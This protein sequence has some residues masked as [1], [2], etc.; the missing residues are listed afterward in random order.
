MTA[1]GNIIYYTSLNVVS[2]SKLVGE[3]RSQQERREFQWEKRPGDT[4]QILCEIFGLSLSAVAAVATVL[5]D[6]SFQLPS[7]VTFFGKIV[8]DYDEFRRCKDAIPFFVQTVFAVSFVV[9]SIALFLANP[10]F[11]RLD[12]AIGN[13]QLGTYPHTESTCETGLVFSSILATSA[14]AP[15]HTTF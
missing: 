2:V 11:P 4:G 15:S 1:N 14:S 6:T 8:F 12:H 5:R 3:K 9:V 7:G 13:Q 10:N